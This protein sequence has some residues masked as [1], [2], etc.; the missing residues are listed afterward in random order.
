MNRTHT[1]PPPPKD[2]TGYANGNG[3]HGTKEKEEPRFKEGHS[4]T[5]YAEQNIYDYN[6]QTIVGYRFL[7]RGCGMLVIA[8]TGLGKSTLSIQLAILWSVGRNAFGIF[9]HKSRRILII[10]SE[11]DEG[12][13]VEMAQMAKQLLKPEELEQCRRNTKLIQCN[14]LSGLRLIEALRAELAQAKKEERPYDLI[15]LNPYQAYLGGDIYKTT[16]NHDFL[17]GMLNPVLRDFNVAIIIICHTPKTRYIKFDDLNW[18]DLAQIGAGASNV[19]DWA[20]A[21]LAIVPQASDPKLFRFFAAKRGDRIGDKWQE[22]GRSRYFS[23][24][25]NGHV[26]CWHDASEEQVKAATEATEA[27]AAKNG[28]QRKEIDLK[29]LFNLC[30]SPLEWISKEEFQLNA[31]KT[32]WG[33]GLNLASTLLKV[34]V[35]KG[36]VEVEERPRPKTNAEKFYRRK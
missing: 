10:Q 31:K 19:S 36:L 28:H 11:D 9:P 4:I 34:G 30:L 21:I 18:W 23:H 27:K 7:C 22:E 33:I 24:A 25:P 16:D 26:M 32:I 6:T 12:D 1:P 5:W 3:A 15:I 8:P 20:R 17:H 29:K 35:E 13:C 2:R 14:D